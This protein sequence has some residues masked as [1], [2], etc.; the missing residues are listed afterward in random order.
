M[1]SLMKKRRFSNSM[2]IPVIAILLCQGSLS[3]AVLE[4]TA[5]GTASQ[6]S[7]WNGGIYPAAFAVDG[8]PDTFSHT[9]ITTRDNSWEL[10]FADEHEVARV[11]V[12][13]RADCCPGRASGV[14]VRAL[15]GEGDSVFNALL[16]D[17]G[18][19]GTVSFTLPE[20]AQVK[21]FRIGFENGATNPGANTTILHLG[22]VKVFA[23]DVPLPAITSFTA[24]DF[25]IALR[26][27]AT[28][29]WTTD[30]VSGVILHPGGSAVPTNG[31]MSVTPSVSTIYSLEI[32]NERGRFFE[33]LGVIVDGNL[34]EP[35]VTEFVASNGGSSVR[36]EGSTPD[37]IEIW[38]PNPGPLDLAGYLLSD[39][40]GSFTFSSVSIPSR[41]FL[42]IDAADLSVDG[43]P[44]TGF[45]LSR[46]AGSVLV[47]SRPGGEI[48]Q[49]LAYPRQF[50]D[51]AYGTIADGSWRF[52]P[53]PTPGHFNGGKSWEGVVADTQFSLKRGFYETAQAVVITTETPDA[54][55]YYTIDGSE[56]SPENPSAV[57]YRAPI[58]V[59]TTTV[60]RALAFRDGWRPT[61]VGT[62]TYL[63]AG[64]VGQQAPTP[65]GFPRRWVPNL[66]GVQS[67][68]SKYAHFGMNAGVLAT[69]P[70]TDQGGADFELRDALTSIPT[71]SL[72]LDAD[73]LFDPITGLHVNAGKRG[74]VWERVASLEI[75]DP[76]SGRN[77]QVNCGIRMH[78]GWN[79]FS[80]MLKKSFRIY[81]RSEYGDGKLKYPLFPGSEIE[82]FDQLILRSG[83]GKAWASPWRSLGGGGNSLERV[84]YLRDQI[85][86]D[87]QREMGHQSIPGTF[88]HLYLNGHYWGLYN[89]VERPT[90]HFAAARFGGDDDDYDV[91]KWSRGQ[92]HLVAA[93][94]DD[95]WNELINRVR[96]NVLNPAVYAAIGERLDLTNFVDYI[97]VNH[98]AG[99]TDWI[100]NNVYAMRNRVPG[101]PFRFYCWDSEE[102]FL[103]VGTDIS[104]SDVADTCTEIHRALRA[105]PE[106]RLLFADRARKHLFHDGALTFERTREILDRHV[107]TIDRAIVGESARWGD[108][109]RPADPYDRADWLKEIGNLRNNYLASRITTTLTQLRADGLYPVVDAP[110]FLPGRGGRVEVGTPVTLTADVGTI[111]YTLDGT[112]P[113]LPGGGV[114]PGALEFL[115]GLEVES[116]VALE[117]TWQFLGDGS[118][119]GTSS[120]VAGA[121]GYDAGNW[122]HPDFDDSAW[123]T[124]TS[125]LGYGSISETDLN[126]L[127]SYG[128]DVNLKHRTTYFRKDFELAGTQRFS[129]LNLSVMRDDGV[130]IYLNGHEMVR[131]GF[132]GNV[133]TVDA[134]TLAEGVFGAG[135]GT[136]EGFR[137]PTHLL[138]EGRNVIAVEL[139][140][141]SDSS[142]DLGF[143][144]TL[145]GDIPDVGG[146]IDILGDTFIRTR[147][148]DGGVW[149][150]LDEAHFVTGSRADDLYV[151]ELMYHP[152]EGGAEFLEISNR[153]EVSHR[154]D[155]LKL[156]GGV[157]FDF[158]N[159]SVSELGPGER[160]VL[161]R[162][163]TAF[164]AVYP[165][166]A[167]AGDY[168][169]GL[170]NGGDTVILRTREGE[171]LWSV[172]YYDL[173]PWPSGT[174]GQGRSLVFT[175][176][177]PNNPGSW[178]ASLALGGDPG[179]SDRLA[180][181]EDQDLI[182]YA[183]NGE[184]ALTVNTGSIDLR[185]ELNPGADD[186]SVRAQ[187]SHDLINWSDEGFELSEQ[188][189]GNHGGAAKAWI[190]E[191]GE[192][193]ARRFFR[194]HLLRK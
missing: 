180:W 106:Y 150:A 61:D 109:L 118:D 141:A 172:E 51:L 160:L 169:G 152:E 144:M 185:V 83:N 108:L 163:A 193:D 23:Q 50:K 91:L 154:L 121:P 28:L 139:H 5:L 87:F 156:T 138:V 85:V 105:N 40:S 38:N 183:L 153:G 96:G 86:R 176:G 98:F 15:N 90:E 30:G 89:P 73:D 111:Y 166:T 177:D 188:S 36:S 31:S 117:N 104:E 34:L 124:G 60:L 103:S 191:R 62:Q 48:L 24:N 6:T 2:I 114:A 133:T 70:L 7:E 27:S 19:G 17:P 175:T 148:L 100:D 81:L 54:T 64:Q 174:D 66:H 146:R 80:E 78:G 3:G 72:V 93:G 26:E 194:L 112:D 22:E 110:E 37:W 4:I 82:E 71:L 88:V 158:A 46:V 137:I 168:A 1:R 178:R 186:V 101:G 170:G 132:A 151:S 149:S 56:P 99:N 14:T 65:V 127:V 173:S 140:Q 29:S 76:I 135:E 145:T 55:I 142:S 9:D 126:T 57:P 164:M 59:A 189:T 92:G 45:A 131:S 167:V 125:P 147:I 75:I 129:A 120:E 43:I 20:G 182:S 35:R 52:L 162:N 134:L 12:S 192:A 179:T 16:A 115:N 143:E 136:F 155:D 21:T 32:S 113:R 181:R 84:T 102:S 69:L 128:D 68:V 10:A 130:V 95:S 11:D 159:A 25:E 63:F 42:V 165:G 97:L 116:I 79:R 107:G 74:R 58:Q 123:D 77:E 39:G 47:F 157:Q 33:S 44:A 161:V 67:P 171:I 184:A 94:N 119:L 190:I 49:S 8:D 122:K 18:L 13:M 41:G 187:W 53:E